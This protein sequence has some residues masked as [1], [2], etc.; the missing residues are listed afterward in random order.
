MI[1]RV[2][3]SRLFWMIACASVLLSLGACQQREQSDLEKLKKT[4]A[5]SKFVPVG[6]TN[7]LPELQAK[8]KEHPD[9]FQVQ[10]ELSLRALE[11]REFEVAM[12]G[13]TR[14]LQLNPASIAAMELHAQCLQQLGR[15]SEAVSEWQAIVDTG[16]PHSPLIESNLGT[17]AKMQGRLEEAEKWYRKALESEDKSNLGLTY[18][19][20]ADVLIKKEKL[21]DATQAI[22]QGLE[23]DANLPYAHHLLGRIEFVKAEY[24]RAIEPL[25]EEVKRRPTAWESYLLLALSYGRLQPPQLDKAE[26]SLVHVK[27]LRPGEDEYYQAM[28]ADL[29]VDAGK[30]AEGKALALQALDKLPAFRE[31]RRNVAYHALAKACLKLGDQAGAAAYHEKF[32]ASAGQTDANDPEQRR[33]IRE[34]DSLFGGH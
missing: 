26:D 5:G 4:A 12:D 21:D 6:G 28:L 32:R 14:A 25:Q 1:H 24:A 22:R 2:R 18:L 27:Q 7:Q 16:K 17:Y 3:F 13:A 30:V 19:N 8:A 15:F 34:M 10:Y 29:Y 33:R 31:D 11:A 23:A 9:D 20:L